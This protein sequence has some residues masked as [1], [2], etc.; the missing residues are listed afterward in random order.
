[1]M[2]LKN[3]LEGFA[4]IESQQPPII[5]CNAEIVS[6]FDSPST[7]LKDIQIAL[8]QSNVNE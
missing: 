1:M 8:A 4:T 5:K 3:A 6:K 2:K 7:H